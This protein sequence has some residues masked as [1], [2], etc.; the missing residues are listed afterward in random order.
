MVERRP[1]FDFSATGVGSVPFLNV[2]HTCRTII[3]SL[4]IP[5]WPQFVKRSPLE[6]MSIQYSEGLPRLEIID[7]KRSLSVSLEKDPEAELV[8][9]YEHFLNQ[10]LNY[11]AMTPEYAPG[12]YKMLELVEQGV[13]QPNRFI[14]GQT[15]GPVTFLAG[16]P[17]TDGKPVL[18]NHE[19]SEALVQGLAIKALWQVHKLRDTGREAILFIDEPY[20]SGFGSAF[21]PIERHQVIDMLRTV[22]DYVRHH[23]EAYVGIHCCG[24]TDWA[25]I[26]EA[27]P[28]IINF[29]A[30]EYMDYFLLYSTEIGRF[31]KTGGSIAWGMVPTADFTGEET[32]EVLLEKLEEGIRRLQDWGIDPESI[33]CRSIL[34][35]ACGMGTMKTEAA[36]NALALLVRLCHKASESL[37]SFRAS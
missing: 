22:I 19:L 7:E 31:L 21:S 33:A 32:V 20:L 29:D 11:F 24:N 8:Q 13:P 35:P 26:A 34:T 9:F 28:D 14:K 37:G 18:H 4:P 25:M 6:D 3:H 15:V 2:E 30:F 36:E 23:S 10:D 5:F 12:L 1:I 27:G 16:I 17:D